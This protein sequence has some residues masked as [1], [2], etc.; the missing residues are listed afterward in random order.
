MPRVLL[1]LEGLAVLAFALVAYQ[2]HGDGWLMFVVLF[3]APDLSFA[4]YAAG[5]RIGSIGYNSIHTYIGP[6]ALGGY[7]VAA[8]GFFAVSLAIIWAAHIGADRS[9]GFGLK[10]PGS[11]GDTHLARV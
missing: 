5:P 9:L 8:D 3:L 1:R 11:F 6:L 2:H 4:G 10:Y 7:G